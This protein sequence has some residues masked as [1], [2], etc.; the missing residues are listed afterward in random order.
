MGFSAKMSCGMLCIPNVRSLHKSYNTQNKKTHKG[1][2]YSGTTNNLQHKKPSA[3]EEK[4][5]C[6]K[7]YAA[8]A[9][10]MH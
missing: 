5:F 1:G 6:D 7:Q 3:G 2:I 9:T 10:K 8:I 4:M